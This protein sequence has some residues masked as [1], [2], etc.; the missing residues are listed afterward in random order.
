[1]EK[2]N[3]IRY[4]G[5]AKKFVWLVNTLFNKVLH[6]NEKRAFYFYLKLNELFGQ[7]N[8]LKDIGKRSSGSL[9]TYKLLCLQENTYK[10]SY[11]P[12]GSPSEC[13]H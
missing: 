7:P 12:Q 10:S 8:S 3:F 4:I 13:V 2:S 11:E 1:M 9:E 5:L 6:E